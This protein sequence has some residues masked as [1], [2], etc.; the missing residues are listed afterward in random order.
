MKPNGWPSGT[1]TEAA[2]SARFESGRAESSASASCP[3]VRLVVRS[4]VEATGVPDDP[5]TERIAYDE[6]V[7]LLASQAESLSGLRA[8]AGTLLAAAS[9][10]TG[11]LAPAALEV[12]DPITR[13]VVREFDTLA[14]LATGAFGLVVVAAL[15]V[16]W[17]YKW[18]FGHSA[19]GLMD[20]LLDATPPAN[21]ATVLR[22][23][24]YYNEENHTANKKTLA[25]L[26]IVFEVGCLLL[27]AEIALWIAAIAR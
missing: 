19:H 27:A 1:P 8:R 4:D 15:V 7:R 21:E 9:L 6:S 2:W 3:L 18:T 20:H 10:A 16:L 12:R 14:W 5:V 23:L 22:H 17:P 26:H 13:G 25:R 11:F 24:S